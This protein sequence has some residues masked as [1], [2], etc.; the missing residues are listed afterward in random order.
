MRFLISH[1]PNK[2]LLFP[3][4]LAGLTSGMLVAAP[5]IS[6]P[7]FQDG[8]AI[9]LYEDAPEVPEKPFIP[10]RAAEEQESEFVKGNVLKLQPAWLTPLTPGTISKRKATLLEGYIEVKEWGKAFQLA[11]RASI[12]NPDN[13][14][15]IKQAAALAALAENYP[16]ADSYFRMYLSQHRTDGPYLIGYAQVLIQLKLFDLAER[17]NRKALQLEP[18]N[19]LAAYTMSCVH[20]CQQKAHPPEEKERWY[21]TSL[22]EKQS[23]ASWLA[24][25][26]QRLLNVLD[27]AGLDSLC[28][29]FIGDGSRKNMELI[30]ETLGIIDDAVAGKD[31]ARLLIYYDLLRDYG[32]E[33]MP[34]EQNAAYAYLQIGNMERSLQMMRDLSERHPGDATLWY[35]MG[36]ILT[37]QSSFT[38]AS[39]SFARAVQIEPK[40][41]QYRFAQACALVADK[42]DDKAWKLL[43]VLG[44]ENPGQLREWVEGEASYLV[45]IRRDARYER[46][47]SSEP[48]SPAPEAE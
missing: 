47:W 46:L 28:S 16:K 32:V 45:K 18:E 2:G 31:W 8:M 38:E 10:R 11:D 36:Y 19:L 43:N 29:L 41:G 44:Q 20:E 37:Q 42:Q 17:I 1:R 23:L 35:R 12:D 5:I 25:D 26:Q 7:A 3:L 34:L 33:S 30:P 4:F 22:K 24:D 21:K 9:D 6:D 40:V 39:D 14:E 13:L 15:L 48:A 27:T